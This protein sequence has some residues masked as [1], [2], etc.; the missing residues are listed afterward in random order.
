MIHDEDVVAVM[1]HLLCL[2]TD[3]YGLI[4]P[5]VSGGGAAGMIH[6]EDVVAGSPWA[7]EVR[8]GGHPGGRPPPSPL[9]MMRQPLGELQQGGGGGAGGI[10]FGGSSN[11]LVR[12]RRPST[13][14]TSL[15]AGGGGGTGPMAGARTEPKQQQGRLRAQRELRA[16]LDCADLVGEGGS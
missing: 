14:G 10:G 6:D 8:G 5:R 4:L 1:I 15:A 3:P 11:V 2:V 9:R 12:Q 7:P 16:S 13:A